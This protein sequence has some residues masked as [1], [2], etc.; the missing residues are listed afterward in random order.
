M[1]TATITSRSILNQIRSRIL[2]SGPIP[3]A[4]YMRLALAQTPHVSKNSSK[5][6]ESNTNEQGYY[7]KQD[8]FGQAGDFITSPEITQMFGELIGVW[9]IQCWKQLRGPSKFNIVELGPGRGTLS[10]DMLKVFNRFQPVIGNDVSLNLVEISPFLSQKQYEVICSSDVLKQ[11]ENKVTPP[12]NSYKHGISKDYDFPVSWY[13]DIRDVPKEFSFYVAHEFF[14]A[15]PVHKLQK[16]DEGWREVLVDVKPDDEDG[17]RF[18]IS[19]HETPMLNVL[20]TRYPRLFETSRNHLEISMDAL[21]V[22]EE[23]TTR[24]EECGGIAV[25]IDYGHDGTKEDTFRAFRKHQLHD[26]LKDP[27]SADITADVDFSIIKEIF[28]D[29]ALICGPVSQQTFLSRV[30]IDLRLDN[31]LNAAKTEVE[32]DQLQSGYKMIMDDMGTRF[33]FI[34]LFPKVLEKYLG[35]LKF[36]GFHE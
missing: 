28:S 13:K 25:I 10:K 21:L 32:K 20:R 36:A 5:G 7:M 1:A 29:K 12:P 31:L 24:L 35:R 11:G 34:S 22:L 26:P 23:L 4:D 17:F 2:M 15:L 19:R 18:V 3:V 27:G 16:V 30:G 8:V 33:H 9:G 14:D 6:T